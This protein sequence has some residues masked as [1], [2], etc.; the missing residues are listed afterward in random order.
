MAAR[1]KELE[2][3][4]APSNEE[5]DTEKALETRKDLIARNR[6]LEQD[7]KDTLSYGFNTAVE[8]LKSST[9]GSSL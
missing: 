8:G 1:V 3:I 4:V 5:T 9:V 6:V 2:E 7:V